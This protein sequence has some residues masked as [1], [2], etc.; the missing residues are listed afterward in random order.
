MTRSQTKLDNFATH[1]GI[2]I[3]KVI[4]PNQGIMGQRAG[5][6]KSIL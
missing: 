4:L 3:R 6:I 5:N 2:S 1:L